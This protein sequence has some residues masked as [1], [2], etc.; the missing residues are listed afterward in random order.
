MIMTKPVQTPAPLREAGRRAADLARNPVARSLLAAGLVTAA[1]ALAANKN[2]RDSAKRGARNAREAAEAAADAAADNAN[3]IGAAMINAATEAVRRMMVE[4]TPDPEGVEDSEGAGLGDLLE[5]GEGLA[6]LTGYAR[7]RSIESWAGA[8]AG[9]GALQKELGIPR[10]TLN[11]WRKRGAVIGLLRGERKHVYPLDQFV[12]ARPLKGMRAVSSA[13]G[14][15]GRAWLWLRQPH[16]RFDMETP[17]QALRLGL[18]EEV[19]QAAQR[20]FI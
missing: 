14:D 12:D 19:I 13:A 3:K 8:V 20:D 6:R 10:S 17:L 4:T 7:H 1:A 9:P 5:D 15:T 18:V 11:E 16:G 2:V